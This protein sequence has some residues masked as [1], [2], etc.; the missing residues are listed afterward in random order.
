MLSFGPVHHLF[1]Y[2]YKQ[3]IELRNVTGTSS[4]DRLLTNTYFCFVDDPGFDTPE[5]PFAWERVAEISCERTHS[6]NPLTKV[7]IG[8]RKHA[9]FTAIR[10]VESPASGD[11]TYDVHPASATVPFKD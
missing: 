1:A 7:V 2:Y 3:P 6:N 8:T 11:R 5:I 4:A 10:A 9:D